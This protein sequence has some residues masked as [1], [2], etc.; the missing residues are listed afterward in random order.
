MEN[1]YEKISTKIPENLTKPSTSFKKHVWLA[2]GGLVLFVIAYIALSWWFGY[3]SY[4]LF[5]DSLAGGK[6][7]FLNFLLA[8]P[9]L[10][11]FIFMIKALFFIKKGG[12][13][14][15]K[16]ITEKEEPILF[17]YLH[18]LADEAGAP[19]PHKVFL[20]SR[21]NASVSYDLSVLNLFFPSK[22]NLEIGIGLIN[23][24]NLGEFKAVLA[25]E[26]GHFAQRSMLVGRWVYMAHQIAAHIIGQRDILDKFLNTISSVDIRIAWIGWILSIIVWSIRSLIEIFFKIVLVAHRALSREMEFNADLIAVSL[27]GSDALIHA[28]HRLQAADDAYDKSLDMVNIA[29]TNKKAVVDMFALQNNAIERM[30]YILNQKDYGASPIVPKENPENNRVFTSKLANPPKMWATHPADHDRENNA[31]KVYINAFIDERSAWSLFKNPEGTK[32][33]ITAELIETAKVETTPL[34]TEE[35]IEEQNKIFNKVYYNPKYRGVYL[36]RSFFRNYEN[37]NDIYLLNHSFKNLKNEITSLYPESL[38]EDL[39]ILKTI[40]EEQ[41]LLTALKEKILT[42]PGGVIMYRG[43]QISRKDLPEVIKK[44]DKELITANDKVISHD[45]LS[46]TISLEAAKQAGNGWDKYLNNLSGILHFT[47]HTRANVEDAENVLYNVLN[48]VMADGKV[49]SSELDR[50]LRAANDLRGVLSKAFTNSRS[51]ELS[52]EFLDK[53]ETTSWQEYIGTF[54]LVHADRDNINKW[55]EVIESWTGTIKSAL[56]A[57]RSIALE[58]LLKSEEYVN[59]LVLSEQT[60]DMFPPKLSNLPEKYNLLIPGKE[61]PIQKKL[62]WWD[63]FQTADGFFPSI[64]KLIV[65]ALVVGATV[66]AGGYIGTSS[67]AI[68]NGLAKDVIVYV[69]DK[70]VKLSPYSSEKI[71]LIT[72][73]GISIK[74][75]SYDD[76]TEI[77]AF[78]PNTESASKTYV[79]NIANAATLVKWTAFYGGISY[80]DNKYLGTSRWSTTNADYVFEEPPSSVSTRGGSTTR[81]VLEAYSDLAPQTLLNM[82]KSEDDISPMVLAHAKWDDR[83]SIHIMTW[84]TLAQEMEEFKT[85][86]K[87]RLDQNP[88][89]TMLL[90]MLQESATG[91]TKTKVC[92]DHTDLANANPDN[93]NYFYLKTRCMEDGIAQNN[94]FKNGH[95]K[96]PDNPWLAF[97]S[98]YAFAE[99]KQ[100][101]E[102]EN[103]MKIAISKEPALS[104]YISIDLK[105]I[106]NLLDRNEQ[107][108]LKRDFKIDYLDYIE[109]LKTESV[110]V[111]NSPD[112]AYVLLNNGELKKAIVHVQNDNLYDFF[113]RQAAASDNANQD[114][115]ETA[116]LLDNEKGIDGYSIWSAL[117][118]AAKKNKNPEKFRSKVKELYPEYEN[119]IYDFIGLVKNKS[120]KEAETKLQEMNP[121]ELG[122]FYAMGTVILGNQAPKHWRKNA[123]RLL[124]ITERP[125][126]D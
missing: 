23:V 91:E 17:N 125:Y 49:T 26:F 67:L 31:K 90:R 29:L 8:L 103:S 84:L 47:E 45:K 44:V 63:R 38:N 75:V 101:K 98:G 85:I 39:E 57:L 50:L 93:G 12:D 82:V 77:E 70:E 111:R 74:T 94:A 5:S 80:N 104:Y 33:R 9:N 100:W 71:D 117:G 81:D 96:W 1:F 68:Y 83:N 107:T 95:K 35:S 48:V 114:I 13:P 124:F 76:Q 43:E 116:L 58:D 121:F 102:A 11:L 53:L 105:R 126:F 24:L 40:N 55:M 34:S 41:V 32:K 56:S 46:R 113:I 79:Y 25:H 28:L 20:S 14:N 37:A 7:S 120:I 115:I 118:L 54:D 72:S 64:V 3:T 88:E 59:N 87:K 4:R 61:R 51:I 30:R 22:K 62:G 92:N 73:N 15:Q 42:A 89:D 123:K 36:D 10:F 110:E 106:Q 97:A 6:N 119:L 60:S 66:F 52:K 16:E 19:R 65:A 112:Y 108:S 27:T 86:L 69:D 21:V 99:D 18:Q 122:S 2:M 78:T 109:N